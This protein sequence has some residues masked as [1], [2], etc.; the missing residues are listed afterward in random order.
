M[1][2]LNRMVAEGEIKPVPVFVDSP[3]AVNTTDVFRRHPEY[4]DQETRDFVR[5]NR[6]PALEFPG[7]TYIRSVEE[8]KALERPG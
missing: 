1:F 4:F 2:D 5:N 7:L 6:H 8:S 3:L